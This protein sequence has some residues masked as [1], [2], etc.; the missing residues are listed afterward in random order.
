[1]TKQQKKLLWFLKVR[2][3]FISYGYIAYKLYNYPYW[4]DFLNRFSVQNSWLLLVFSFLLMPIN[5]VLEASKWKILIQPIEQIS[6]KRAI[7]I[8]SAAIS[9]GIFTPNRI[10]ELAGRV[11][12]LN[13]ANR[14]SGL[15]ASIVGSYAQQ[16]ITIGMALIAFL[17][18]YQ[19]YAFIFLDIQNW[20][21]LL[22]QLLGTVLFAVM[23][24]IYFRL[25]SVSRFFRK[26]KW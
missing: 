4:P 2:V 25:N 17:L 21:M 11:F 7:K 8:V 9:Y 26:K 13:K 3:V 1:M 6:L 24:I 10:G 5:W 18:A 23:L 12:W 14:M 20:I 16:L 19:K 22:I 15:F